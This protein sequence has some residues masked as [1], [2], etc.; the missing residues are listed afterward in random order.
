MRP[1]TLQ[2]SL[3]ITA[4]QMK[5]AEANAMA[6]GISA[7]TLMEHAGAALAEAIVA[8]YVPCPILVVCGTGNN[9]GDG[10]VAALKLRERGWAVKLALIGRKEIIRAEAAHAKDAWEKSG[11]P[12]LPFSPSQLEGA[13]LVVDALFGTG[14][15]RP[16]EG[17]ALDAVKAINASNKPVVAADMPSGVHADSGAVMG[18]AVRADV[19]VAFACTKRGLT[20]LPGK[21]YA[22]EILVADIGITQQ[23]L[24]I[25]VTAA[26]NNPALW[27]STYPLPTL[28]SHKYTRGH[29]LIAG[30]GINST[31]ASRLAATAALRAGAGL[32][33][34]A[35]DMESLPVYASSLTAVMTKPIRH[36]SELNALLH[37][38]RITALLIGCG[39]GVG[40][41]TREKALTM[42]ASRKPCVVDADAL[43]LF[44]DDK[45]S[46]FSALHEYCVLTPHAGEFA[47][48]FESNADKISAT[49]EAAKR[50]KAV[51]VFKGSDTVIASPKGFAT[52]NT[53]APPWLATAGSGDVLAGIICGLL[54]QGMPVF[55]AASA[56]VWLHGEAA[57]HSGYGMIAED[58]PALLTRALTT[59]TAIG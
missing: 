46:L 35:C 38:K 8:R 40:E 10:F 57:S 24:D 13:E 53:N 28:E 52:V 5:K 33:S 56:G 17:L 1:L 27:G 25:G 26:I 48:L 4:V 21:L 36:L 16:L 34:V 49:L 15:N 55:E 50:S 2:E 37:D 11:E 32:V 30:G 18:T 44:Q 20:L 41:E 7:S 3:L 23:H 59:L 19:T 42:L 22:G 45:E 58:I 51:V 47:R 14:L 39:T 29:A 9:G 43:T 6:A 54:A 31:G 12:I